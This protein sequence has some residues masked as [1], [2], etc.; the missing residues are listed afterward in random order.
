LKKWMLLIVVEIR[1]MEKCNGKNFT[2]FI[3]LRKQCLAYF[4]MK[5]LKIGLLSKYV[6]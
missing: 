1:W 6:L 5:Q 3:N 4:H 2:V